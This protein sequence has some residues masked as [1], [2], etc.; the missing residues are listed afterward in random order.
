MNLT[1]YNWPVLLLGSGL[2]ILSGC[3]KQ[4]SV[5]P[6]PNTTAAAPYTSESVPSEPSD[7]ALTTSV[8]SALLEAPEIN[9]Y[10]IAVESTKGDVKLTGLLGTQAQ[11]DETVRLVKLIAGV[12]AVHNE[13]AIKQ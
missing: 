1:N 6:A 13:L 7:L 5:A 12:K 3:E 10:D 9:T 11:I 8:K 2:L 4:P